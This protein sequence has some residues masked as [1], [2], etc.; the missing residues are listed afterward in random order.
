MFRKAVPEPVWKLLLV[1]SALDAMK[2][3]Y[4]A[5]GTALTLQLGHRI[6]ADLDFFTRYVRLFWR[7]YGHS[8]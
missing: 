5:G 3:S 4:L 7:T 2:F 8:A 1:L 6:S